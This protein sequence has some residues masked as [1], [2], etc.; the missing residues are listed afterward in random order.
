M[1]RIQMLVDERPLGQFPISIST[2]LALEGAFGIYPEN[3]VSPP[4]IF[5][6]KELVI[7]VAT[8]VRNIYQ[9]LSKE[10]KQMVTPSAI[11]HA[12]VEEMRIIQAIISKDA[13]P[14]TEVTFYICSYDAL[15]KMF[16]GAKLRTDETANQ[17]AYAAIEDTVLKALAKNPAGVRLVTY[18]VDIV[19]RFPASFMITHYPVD[20][21]SI[22][23][24]ER[25]E[26]LESHTGKIKPKTQWYTKLT[27][28]KELTNIPFHKLTLQ[29]FG[30]NGGHFA[31]NSMAI[32]KEV[33]GL[34]TTYGWTPVTT[35]ERIVDCV[36]KVADPAMKG[37]LMSML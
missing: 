35:N 27:N 11:Y 10:V 28:G 26:L 5:A 17:K 29:V 23:S 33:L 34:A 22:R 4:P 18:N 6:V 19:G 1:D 31:A 32:K 3:P 7:N 14:G 20:L 37:L 15:P 13:R 2:S 36:K 16:R 24:F 12:A 8:L 30:D 9:C 21:L 25:L